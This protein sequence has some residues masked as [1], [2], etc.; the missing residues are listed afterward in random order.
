MIQYILIRVCCIFYCIK[1]QLLY[2]YKNF[3]ILALFLPIVL[4]TAEIRVKCLNL[5][6]ISG[7]IIFDKNNMHEERSECLIIRYSFL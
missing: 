5:C 1:K 4:R 2:D 3:A 6:E 7:I